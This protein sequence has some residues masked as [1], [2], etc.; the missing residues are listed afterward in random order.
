MI[1][2]SDLK[3]SL[4]KAYENILKKTT[5]PTTEY[6]SAE[7]V[8]DILLPAIGFEK[9]E[10]WLRN[11]NI[12]DNKERVNIVVKQ[13]ENYVFYVES[14]SDKEISVSSIQQS[15]F[16]MRNMGIKYG[17]LTNGLIYILVSSE[18]KTRSGKEPD[19]DEGIIFR[20]CLTDNKSK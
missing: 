7:I 3:K 19:G 17:I 8:Q 16:S 18:I 12:S 6:I 14:Y 5:I 9:K 20:F 10:E 13:G 15:V 1:C 4:L 2:V 11:K